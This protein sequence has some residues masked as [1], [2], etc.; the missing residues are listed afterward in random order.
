MASSKAAIIRL[1]VA[2]AIDLH[3]SRPD[4]IYI[5]HVNYTYVIMITDQEPETL[6]SVYL[7]DEHLTRNKYTPL[8]LFFLEF[9]PTQ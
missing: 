9:L 8:M 6:C 4:V 5:P 2:I 7:I 3:D 1:Y